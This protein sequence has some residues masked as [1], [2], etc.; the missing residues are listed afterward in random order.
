VALGLAQLE[1]KLLAM[2][3]LDDNFKFVCSGI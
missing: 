1:N 2:E 3:L